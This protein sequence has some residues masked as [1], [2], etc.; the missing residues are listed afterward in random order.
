MT[1]RTLALALLLVTASAPA[2][3][4]VRAS[5]LGTVS[6]VVDG[7]K[8]TITYSRPKVRGRSPLWGTRAVQWGETWTPGA[9]WATT[10]EAS[11]DITLGGRRVPQG[12]YSV[13]MVVRQS[14]DWTF[15]LDPRARLFHMQHPDS[16]ADQIRIPVR[17]T[18]APFTEV[19]TWSFP[20]FRGDGGTIAMQWEKIRVALD[21]T[22]APS[23]SVELPEADA[24]Q[25]VGRW[26]FTSASGSD[27]G[28]EYGFDVTYENRTLRAEF[29]PTDPYLKRFALI[30]VAP[31]IFTVGVYDRDG[32]VYEVLR[33]DMMV[34]FSRGGGVPSG[35]EIRDESDDLWGTGV[36][37]R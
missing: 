3:A 36:R 2:A 24:R 12:R 31:D 17:A 27:R 15:V 23:L 19:L 14:G 4:Q 1:P 9:N 20:D 16:T 37:K 30:R 18:E 21:Y 22:V 33:P 7:T 13:W 26:T 11:K 32:R 5:E 10:L 25:Y 28:K 6:Q 35:F 8:L 34:T 29:I